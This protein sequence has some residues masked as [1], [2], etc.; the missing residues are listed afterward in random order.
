[1][2]SISNYE[3]AT[4]KFYDYLQEHIH[5]LLDQIK[6]IDDNAEFKEIY[7]SLVSIGRPSVFIVNYDKL[8][9]LSENI[10][11]NLDI[12]KF[13]SENDAID[14]EQVE[15][16][17]ASIINDPKLVEAAN[18]LN[19]SITKEKL[20]SRIEKCRS[21]VNGETFDYQFFK[22]MLMGS[23]LTDEEISDVLTYD[24]LQSTKLGKN[25][26]ETPAIEEEKEEVKGPLPSLEEVDPKKD[27]AMSIFEPMKATINHYID[28]FYYLI[29]V[30]TP[31][32]VEYYKRVASLYKLDE[33]KEMF[34]DKEET[35]VTLLFKLIDARDQTQM[36]FDV[37]PFSADAF[38]ECYSE[39]IDLFNVTKEKGISFEKLEEENVAKETSVF[40][41]K[42][43]VE[44]PEGFFAGLDDVAIKEFSSLVEELEKGEYDYKRGYKHSMVQQNDRKDLNIFVN[45]KS[46]HAISFIRLKPADNIE[47]SLIV[48]FAKN[49]D[50]FGQT[51]SVIRKNTPIDETIR[52]IYDG[53]ESYRVREDYFRDKLDTLAGKREETL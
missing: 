32:Q 34:A 48:H 18:N 22:A 30:K 47:R 12:I 1:M 4:N 6:D 16:A 36:C 38:D 7:D 29:N 21:I 5:Y 40:F 23:G 41:L 49:S 39:L 3:K 51:L 53:D 44:N 13:F 14:T 24:A 25:K 42:D 35:F 45:K 11:D 33:I 31:S 52:A 15:T 50:I 27:E 2:L 8:A 10:K 46:G 26:E 19:D 20:L 28:S 9:S 37:K 43:M 17:M